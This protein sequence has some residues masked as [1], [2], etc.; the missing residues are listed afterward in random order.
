VGLDVEHVV[1]GSNG[2][3]RWLILGSH[4]RLEVE[5]ARERLRSTHRIRSLAIRRQS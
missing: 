2:A 5:A 1:R 4:S 3:S